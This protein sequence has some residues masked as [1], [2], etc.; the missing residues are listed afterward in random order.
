M[1][2][3]AAGDNLFSLVS[4]V[5]RRLL[6]AEERRADAQVSLLEAM[7][8]LDDAPKSEKSAAVDRVREARAELRARRAEAQDARSLL[9]RLQ[10]APR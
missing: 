5:R 9:A 2:I 8:A 6:D 10:E 3:T 1:T 4:A 7:S